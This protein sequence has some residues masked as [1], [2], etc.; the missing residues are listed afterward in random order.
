MFL[1][2]AARVFL[3]EAAPVFLLEFQKVSVPGDGITALN[4]ENPKKPKL[5]WS[6]R[7]MQSLGWEKGAKGFS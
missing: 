2:E 6:C 5:C 3:L 7:E 1:L 4:W